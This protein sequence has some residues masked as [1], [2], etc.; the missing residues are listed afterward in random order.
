MTKIT[1]LFLERTITLV[2]DLASLQTLSALRDDPNNG[3]VTVFEFV[4][5]DGHFK[6]L[7]VQSNE[8]WLLKV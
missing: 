3:C 5:A 7:T 4:V 8:Y 2:C 1:G 6:L